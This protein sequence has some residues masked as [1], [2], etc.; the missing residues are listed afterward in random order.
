MKWLII[1]CCC[2]HESLSRITTSKWSV[3]LKPGENPKIRKL[4]LCSLFSLNVFFSV[5]TLIRM[6]YQCSNLNTYL[7]TIFLSEWGYS[8]YIEILLRFSSIPSFRDI[9][10]MSAAMLHFRMHICEY[11][12][13][14]SISPLNIKL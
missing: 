3:P 12:M 6:N 11:R 2:G 14:W 13:T 5:L 1:A 9:K 8:V 7:V 10:N 4:K